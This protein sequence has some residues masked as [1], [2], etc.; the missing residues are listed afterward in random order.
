MTGSVIKVIKISKMERTSKKTKI[1]TYSAILLEVLAVYWIVCSVLITLIL[2]QWNIFAEKN[3]HQFRLQLYANSFTNLSKF[4][5]CTLDNVAFNDFLSHVQMQSLPVSGKW[6]KMFSPDLLKVTCW[7]PWIIF[8]LI[9][10]TMIIVDFVFK[11]TKRYFM[12]VP[13]EKTSCCILCAF[14]CLLFVI[15]PLYTSGKS[16]NPAQE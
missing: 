6:R 16:F 8:I 12:E 5:Y 9:M 3:H 2:G 13:H 4:T 7:V 15:K 10:Y 1:K 11:S 14:K